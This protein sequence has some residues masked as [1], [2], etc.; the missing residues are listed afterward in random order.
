MG[1]IQQIQVE[2]DV[3]AQLCLGILKDIQKLA[4]ET[5]EGPKQGWE[6]LSYHEESKEKKSCNDAGIKST[7]SIEHQFGIK[8]N[9]T[10]HEGKLEGMLDDQISNMKMEVKLGQL[11]KICTQLKKILAKIFLRMQK[12][13]VP[14]VCKFG[15][16]HKN[17][18]DEVMPIV[19]VCVGNYEIMD[20]L[21]DDGFGINISFEHLRRKLGLK[22]PQSAPFMVRMV[23]QKKVQPIGLIRNLKINLAGCTFKIS[24][25]VL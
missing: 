23:D 7:K 5:K 15:T 20:V 21:L 10:Y 24:M 6:V 12:E 8:E 14:N 3:L 16:H 2:M 1:E 19:H 9:L 13:H 11:I 17:D 25:T 22:K 4:I 18:F